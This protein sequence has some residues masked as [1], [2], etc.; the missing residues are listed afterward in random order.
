MASMVLRRG[1]LLRLPG[2]TVAAAA[3]AIL[4]SC[5]GTGREADRIP[6]D[7]S[8]EFLSLW[9]FRN[10]DSTEAR[11]REALSGLPDDAGPGL[12]VQLLTRI[13]RAQGLHGIWPAGAASMGWRSTRPT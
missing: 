3:L 13:A 11:F 1:R 8:P 12:E 4:A 7:P 9:D 2:I 5:T 6:E 10:P